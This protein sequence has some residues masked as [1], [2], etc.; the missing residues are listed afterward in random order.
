VRVFTASMIRDMRHDFKPLRVSSHGKPAGNG[1]VGSVQRQGRAIDAEQVSSEARCF[2]FAGFAICKS[3]SVMT[4][5]L[6]VSTPH[7]DDDAPPKNISVAGTRQAGATRH[8][9][10]EETFFY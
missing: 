6:V 9:P 2:S 10:A 3:L 1:S 4:T 5:T 7:P 8:H